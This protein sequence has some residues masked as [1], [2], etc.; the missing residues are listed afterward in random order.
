MEEPP[1]ILRFGAELKDQVDLIHGVTESQLGLLQEIRDVIRER[2]NL[3][4]DYSTKLLALTK[5]AQEKKAKRMLGVVLGQE[6]SKQYTDDTIRTSTLD[7]ALQAFLTSW[8]ET[9][10]LHS[11]F[12]SELGNVVVEDLRRL[13][14]KKE[15][16]N[17]MVRFLC[18]WRIN[19]RSPAWL[20]FEWRW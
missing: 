4:K 19:E 1:E 8:E 11:T 14:R 10:N 18:L 9:A 6:P 5:K 7:V 20:G 2:A 17:R 12:A 3:E 16:T 15:E 13:E